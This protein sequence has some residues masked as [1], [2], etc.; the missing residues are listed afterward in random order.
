[1]SKPRPK[2]HGDFTSLLEQYHLVLE[3]LVSSQHRAAIMTLTSRLHIPWHSSN[4]TTP[5]YT[6]ILPVLL[7][8]PV[9]TLTTTFIL[10]L[11]AAVVSSNS[12]F[13]RVNGKAIPLL[14]PKRWFELSTAAARRR[15]DTDSWNMTLKGIEKYRGEPF[16]L[17]T[18]E[19]DGIEAVV[20]PPRYM[21]ELKNDE[22]LSF[23]A[24]KAK[25]MH[26]NFPGFRTIETLDQDNRIIQMMTQQDLTR[27][28]P[29]L[30]AALS[31]ECAAALEDL[32]G[33]GVEWH[34][35]VVRSE[36]S[37]TMVARLST[38]VFMGPESCYDREWIDI[39]IGYTINFM[40]ANMA[41]R[42]YPRWLRPLVNYV[43]PQC[44]LLRAQERRAQQIIEEKLAA[45]RAFRKQEP[46]L[47]S[48]SEA[49]PSNALDWFES[50]HQKLG[51]E[52]NPALTQLMLS[53]AAIHTT[54][55]L[56]TQV[57]LDLAVHQDLIEPLRREIIEALDGKPIDKTAT[58]KMKLL[59]SVMKETQ[60]M[61]PMQISEKSR[62]RL[63]RIDGETTP[64]R[65]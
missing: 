9:A 61:K 35:I 29:R 7:G 58:Q 1:M 26:G 44:R 39:V 50:Q 37:L 23:T 19:L 63:S 51:G 15:Y 4:L 56:L 34:D 30:T 54:A 20:L 46:S 42:A 10:V 6:P 43:D 33:S 25:S 14:N 52:Y 40:L 47:G 28:L 49:E 2:P 65:S 62:M 45:R 38:L 3:S 57:I 41:L 32:V 27:S 12:K 31:A 16:R 5:S 64:T 60:R 21:E 22:R 53:F 59:D 48:G 18:G 8:G 24:L 11:L 13:P 36:F 17:L 55:D